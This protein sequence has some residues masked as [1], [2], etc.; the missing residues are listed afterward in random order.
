M[1]RLEAFSI[2][3]LDLFFNSLDHLPPHF[4]ARRRGE[5]EIRVYFLLSGS[6]LA[7]DTKWS[8]KKGAVPASTSAALVS[9]VSAHRVSLLREWEAKV[10]SRVEPDE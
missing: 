6:K 3:G 10:S 2:S 7:F 9:A 4:H 5:W 1:P 8:L